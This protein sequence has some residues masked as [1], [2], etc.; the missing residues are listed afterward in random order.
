M[1]RSLLLVLFIFV[2]SASGA[3]A[4][5]WEALEDGLDWGG[6]EASSRSSRGDSIVHVLRIDPNRF[7]LVLL[8]Q[9]APD[10]SANKTARQW[11]TENNLVG[12]INASMF[13]ED[14]RTSVAL[15]KTGTHTNSA[16]LSK[17]NAVLAF[18][19]IADGLPRVQIID[20]TCQDFSKLRKL[21][22]SLVQNIRMISCTGQNVWAQ[23][24]KK[25]STAAVGMDKKGRVL[26]IHCR[27]HYSTHDFI[28]VLLSLPIGIKNAMYVEGGAEAQL[29]V[30]SGTR[31]FERVGSLETAFNEDSENALAWPV[32][33]VIGV[34]RRSAP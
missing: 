29:Y 28:N 12:A 9:S 7:D 22:G 14:Y 8:N 27:S 15:M 32:P 24:K 21:Y 20:R 18:D 16:R 5:G 19:P 30:S 13:Q 1:T 25:W 34:K 11:A 26:F 2:A 10:Q 33:N 17:D 3:A 6:F 4:E 23:Q 31:S